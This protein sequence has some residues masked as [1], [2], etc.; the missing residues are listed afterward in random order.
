V[1]WFIVVAPI[2]AGILYWSLEGRGRRGEYI[3]AAIVLAVLA[4]LMYQLVSGPMPVPT[5][6]AELRG[7]QFLGEHGPPL[8]LALAAL[9]VTCTV[10]SALFRPRVTPG[11]PTTTCPFCAE[12]IL[13]AACVCK[14]C[15]RDIPG[16]RR[17]FTAQ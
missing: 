11:P 8:M 17:A 12:T 9:A 10:A 13:P 14:H 1:Y 7:V 3:A 15:S 2:C 6:K 5:S 4:W 16:T